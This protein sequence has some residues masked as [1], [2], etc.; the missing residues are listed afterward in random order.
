MATVNPTITP[1]GEHA[2]IFRWTPLTSANPDGA[3]ISERYA[4]FS[5]RS[6]QI[7]GTFGT[8]TVHW[9]GSND[10]T[11]YRPMTDPQGGAISKTAVSIEQVLEMTLKQ[12]PNV[13]GADGATSISVTVFARRGR[14][15][16]EV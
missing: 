9:E 13:T 7:E 8:G 2:Y 15:G 11:N 4:D 16:V 14:G 1:V 3:P 6:V 5:D 10:G 12:R